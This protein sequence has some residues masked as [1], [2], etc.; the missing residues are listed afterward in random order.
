[1]RVGER[2]IFAPAG[3]PARTR[4]PV[5]RSGADS[6]VTVKTPQR[7]LAR[8]HAGGLMQALRT[9]GVLVTALLCA[10][11]G[12]SAVAPDATGNVVSLQEQLDAL[13][14][15]AGRIADASAIKRLQRAYGYYLDQKQWDALAD[16]FADDGTIEIGLDGV[17]VGK[18]RVRQ[19][20]DALGGGTT[21][22]RHGEL[23]DHV[24]LQPV[25]T[26]SEDGQSARGR[27]R[28][29]LMTGQLGENA[30]WGEGVYENEYVKQDG[31]WK[32]RSLHWYNTFRVPY[33]GGWAKNRDLSG[34]VFVSK[35]LPPDRPPTVRY[36]VWPDVHTP[37]FHYPATPA[38]RAL[39]APADAPSG[40]DRGALHS[41]VE[42]L[43]RRVQKVAD[44]DDIEQ[45]VSMYG[46]YLDKQQWDLFTEL[47]AENSQME[48]SQRGVYY[49]KQG[50][51][52]AVELFGPQNIE[53]NHLHNHIQMQPVITVAPDGR[54]AWVR[55]RALSMLGTFNGIGV[56]GD[57][58]Y[59]NEMVKE[60]GVWRFRVDHVYTTFFA[61]YEPGWGTGARGTPKASPKIPPDAPPTEVYESFPEVFIPKFHFHNPVTGGDTVV[62]PK[63]DTSRLPAQLREQVS[64]IEKLVARLE[65]EDAIENLQRT[66]GFYTDKGQW[67]DAADLF[68]DDGTLEIGGG[69]VYVGRD[70]IR[71]YLSR[72][73]PLGLVRGRLFNHLQLQPIVDVS[74]DGTSAQA[75][76]RFI[77]ELG[78][79]GESSTWG[80]GTYQNEYVKE[81]GV[82][83]IRRL[84]AFN[85]FHTPYADGWGKTALPDA[86]PDKDFPPDRPQSV[87]Y[88]PYPSTDLPPFHYAHP[89]TGK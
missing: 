78:T 33:E 17:Y 31:V 86:G 2:A 18:K 63:I 32:I 58:V 68:A 34:G 11:T 80:A 61:P 30:S 38:K 25:I 59:E 29:V 67:K 41:A 62:E 3:D 84:H 26:V 65:D 82:W 53:Q 5:K 88:K 77:A 57:G 71:Q 13:E 9:W 52:R 75:R 4:T 48:I 74:A 19:Y 60:N 44:V 64:R 7:T 83:K 72:I 76:W 42:Q 79:A 40:A 43:R 12:T 8:I 89:V 35:Q 10:C 73:S 28:A 20:L 23:N 87:A 15:E 56:W 36:G 21:G 14:R 70:R 46:Y 22:L 66:Y 45:L 81:N 51:R 27:W 6:V 39:P 55:S 69:G 54:R 24:I 1:M 50:V 85:R 16:L 49:G 47:F 37:A